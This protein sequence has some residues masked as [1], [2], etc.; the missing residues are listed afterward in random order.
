[1][2]NVFDSPQEVKDPQ[3]LMYCF[4]VKDGVDRLVNVV[5]EGENVPSIVASVGF[6]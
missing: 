5:V 1:M 6:P 2:L 4:I 3:V